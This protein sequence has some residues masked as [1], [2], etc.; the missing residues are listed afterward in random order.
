MKFD[1]SFVSILIIASLIGIGYGGFYI[2]LIL[3]DPRS[4][5]LR[6][7]Q[8]FFSPLTVLPLGIIGFG[9]F[10]IA[11]AFLLNV[12]NQNLKS[13]AL[14]VQYLVSVVAEILLIKVLIPKPQI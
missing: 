8:S 3:S 11:D 14:P 9:G 1:K 12:R 7:S 10:I 6:F 13:I 5:W 2:P 4:I